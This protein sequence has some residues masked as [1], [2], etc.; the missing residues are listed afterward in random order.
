MVNEFHFKGPWLILGVNIGLL[1]GA[2]FWGLGS[3]IWGRKSVEWFSFIARVLIVFTRISFNITLLI[4]GVF[5][6]AGGG[7]N[8]YVTLTSL[9][10]VW[11]I[12][13][14]GNLP[15]DSAIFLGELV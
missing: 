11:S 2:A 14:G 3:D 6:V 15:V 7:S 5:A 10:T 4:V 1:V 12:G 8:S 13:V 9:A